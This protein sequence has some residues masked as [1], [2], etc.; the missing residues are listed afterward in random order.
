MREFQ[1]F[2]KELYIGRLAINEKGEY[3]YYLMDH[4]KT[5]CFFSRLNVAPALYTEQ[6]EFGAPIPFFQVRI[7]A[8]DRHRNLECGFVTDDVRLKDIT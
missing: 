2:Y 8:N 5:N 3:M 6:K 7:E 4:S 1:V